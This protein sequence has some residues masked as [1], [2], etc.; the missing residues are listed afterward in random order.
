MLRKS[1][2]AALPFL[3]LIVVVTR[4]E[5]S[6]P[7]APGET[8]AYIVYGEEN[9]KTILASTVNQPRPHMWSILFRN[10]EMITSKSGSSGKMAYSGNIMCFDR[11]PLNYCDFYLDLSSF[12]E[13]PPFG[14]L[15]GFSIQMRNRYKSSVKEIKSS[16]WKVTQT[17]A[18]DKPTITEFAPKGGEPTPIKVICSSSYYGPSSEPTEP[19]ALVPPQC[20]FL[21][22]VSSEH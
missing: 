3:A 21:F 10:S 16:V 14:K 18:R 1:F 5:A 8:K 19:E 12:P 22:L 6:A 2:F 13:Y 11:A 17:G 15:S 20:T 7:K 4:G 9:Y